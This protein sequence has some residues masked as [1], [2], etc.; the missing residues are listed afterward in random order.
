MALAAQ[1]YRFPLIGRADL[2]KEF[3]L[4]ARVASRVP[5]RS[6][7]F[8]RELNRIHQLCQAILDDFRTTP[9]HQDAKATAVDETV[10]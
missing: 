10:F 3:D 8:H 1:L 5:L 9:T 4:L 7:T 2:E 6:V